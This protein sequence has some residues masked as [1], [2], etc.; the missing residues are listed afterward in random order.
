MK[1]PN[2][3]IKMKMDNAN[4]MEVQCIQYIAVVLDSKLSWI[5]HKL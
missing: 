4:I 1:L 2:N 5:P 3:S